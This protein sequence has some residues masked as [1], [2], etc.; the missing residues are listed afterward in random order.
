MENGTRPATAYPAI[1]ATCRAGQLKTIAAGPV[2]LIVA[3]FILVCLEAQKRFYTVFITVISEPAGTGGC[4]LAAG[5]EC[6][7]LCGARRARRACGRIRRASGA[8]RGWGRRSGTAWWVGGVWIGVSDAVR[9]GRDGRRRARSGV[10]AGGCGHG[11]ARHSLGRELRCRVDS[12]LTRACQ[13]AGLA[14]WPGVV[15][16]PA[17]A[18]LSAGGADQPDDDDHRRATHR[19]RPSAVT[20]ARARGRDFCVSRSASAGS[21]ACGESRID[22]GSCAPAPYCRGCAGRRQ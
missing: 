11:R 19:G 13:S 18:P 1:S 16:I 2:Y 5:I 14:S 3:G 9:A 15:F 12:R 10:V 22:R 4:A 8:R 7:D 21:A 17:K 6:R 20:S